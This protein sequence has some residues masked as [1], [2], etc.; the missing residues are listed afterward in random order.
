MKQHLRAAEVELR[1]NLSKRIGFWLVSGLKQW[2]CKDDE[3]G[4]LTDQ[5]KG[6]DGLRDD[7]C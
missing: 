7:L 2:Y 5:G 4:I 6:T 1:S 3:V